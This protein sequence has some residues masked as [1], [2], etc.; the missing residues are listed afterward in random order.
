MKLGVH[1]SYLE[2]TGA[3]LKE[4]VKAAY[5][6]SEARGLGY[7]H[8]QEGPLSDEDAQRC[9]DHTA[10]W[11]KGVNLDYVLGRACKFAVIEVNGRLFTPARWYDHTERD[12]NELLHRIGKVGA[13]VFEDLPE[14]ISA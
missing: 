3:D 7:L 8:Y 11:S 4:C 12:L 2:I 6:L 10:R 14:R 1:M 9:I 13:P 5:A